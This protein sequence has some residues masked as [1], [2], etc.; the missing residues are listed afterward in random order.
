MKNMIALVIGVMLAFM[1]IN[2]FSR[3][4][5]SNTNDSAQS[6]PI[7]QRLQLLHEYQLVKA[8]QQGSPQ[9]YKEL[10]NNAG[11]GL[12]PSEYQKNVQYDI[13]KI[14]FETFWNIW[15]DGNQ[16]FNVS[17]EI[18]FEWLEAYISQLRDIR[19]ANQCAIL[20][21]PIIDAQQLRSI[22][23][24]RTQ[25]KMNRV[26]EKALKNQ[27]NREYFDYHRHD[28]LEKMQQLADYIQ[29]STGH[30]LHGEQTR[31]NCDAM[32]A[33]IQKIQSEPNP[34]LRRI[35]LFGY[36]G[37]YYNASQHPNLIY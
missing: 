32:I 2:Y 28:H 22:L 16:P 24:D 1:C 29:Q 37:H 26:F 11:H 6:S 34:E 18:M 9:K 20:K 31:Q 21:Q 4:S 33:I 17:G 10:K 27:D 12:N 19:R 13:Q 36:F 35:Y 3:P 5:N 23:T 7:E 8:I 25:D 14:Y 30:H 15:G